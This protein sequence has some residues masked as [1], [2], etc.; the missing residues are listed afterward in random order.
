MGGKAKKE[1]YVV[2]QGRKP[3]LYYTWD[4]CQK[5]VNEFSGA[6][7]QGYTNRQNAER[8]WN[9]CE[10]TPRRSPEAGVLATALGNAHHLQN[11]LEAS[12]LTLAKRVR[13]TEER[14]NTHEYI[15]ITSDDEEQPRG[16]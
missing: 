6:K 11:P 16:K 9:G 3:G 2:F 7:F 5:Q 4:E 12:S 8:A 15:V 1:A 13:T 10:Q 14:P